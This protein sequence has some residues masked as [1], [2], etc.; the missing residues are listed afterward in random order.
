MNRSIE[1]IKSVIDAGRV[2]DEYERVG[3]DEAET[4]NI[5]D[6]AKTEVVVSKNEYL[7]H[8]PSAKLDDGVEFPLTIVVRYNPDADFQYIS[9]DICSHDGTL[10]FVLEAMNRVFTKVATGQSIDVRLIDQIH[11]DIRNN[12]L[13]YEIGDMCVNTQF[14]ES[15]N[16]EKP[17]LMSHQ[18]VA[19][20]IKMTL[21]PNEQ[22]GNL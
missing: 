3:W 22:N 12:S 20:P 9:S 4:F 21:V 13:L 15:K 7:F 6:F 8:Y 10:V 18:T 19:L 17:W 16:P 11:S 1:F 14:R 2:G 5:F